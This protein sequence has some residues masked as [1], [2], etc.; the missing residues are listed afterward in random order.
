[1]TT[2]KVYGPF[3]IPV[4]NGKGGR[5]VADDRTDF[6][7]DSGCED[8]VG[9]YIFGIRQGRGT[10]PYYAGRTTKGFGAECFQ[11][12]KLVKYHTL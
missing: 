7:E 11:S 4:T 5:M 3:A 12:H 8:K 9:C 2:F 6:W 10:K 1:M